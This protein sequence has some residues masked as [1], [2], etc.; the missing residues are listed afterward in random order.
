M[1]SALALARR[2]LGHVWPNPTVGCVIVKD[3][4]IVGRGVTAAGGRPHAEAVA[5]A[6]AG[7]M[8]QGATAYVTLEP[9]AHKSKR[10]PDCAGALIAAGVR[11]VVS[12]LIDP[13]P[14][15]SGKGF[16]KLQAAGLHVESGLLAKEAADMNAG[17]LMRINEGR[18]LITLKLATSLD[19]RIATHTGHSQWI[20]GPV[21]RSRAHLLRAENDGIVVG[22][23]T[24]LRDDPS[25]TCRLPGL[26]DRSPVRIVFD[27]RLRLPL[28]RNLIATAKETPTWMVC[29]EAQGENHYRAEALREC[30]VHLFEVGPDEN[31][32]PDMEEALQ[33]LAE[34]GMTRLLIEGGGQLAAS[35]LQAD[36]VD[37][38]AWFR[39]PIVIGG[40]GVPGAV[41]YGVALLEEAN[42]FQVQ[43]SISCGDDVLTLY[44]RIQ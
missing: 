11:R 35:L 21:A 9:C 28:T 14:R 29:L 7:M 19:G 25:L 5:L 43:K 36:L 18:P 37:R 2:G 4:R 6:Q 17:F 15:T 26:Q 23:Q 12:A 33:K 3:G 16:A 39:A 27:S 34:H 10:G 38:L 44:Q 30:G 13:D 24:A 31:G 1:R 42:R 8:A 40:D 41:G 22:I 32:R 20:T